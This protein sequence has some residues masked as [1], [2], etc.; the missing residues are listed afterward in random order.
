[1]EFGL[2]KREKFVLQ[3]KKLI[4]SQNLI[5]HFNRKIQEFEKG[6]TYKEF[7]TEESDGIQCQQIKERLKKE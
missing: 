1:M 7:G 4:H 6:K 5:F 2:D 3:R